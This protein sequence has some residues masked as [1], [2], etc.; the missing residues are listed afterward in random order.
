MQICI[1]PIFP[2]LQK[3]YTKIAEWEH[4]LTGKYVLGHNKIDYISYRSLR[5]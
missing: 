4:N 1:V 3:K 2:S 5:L